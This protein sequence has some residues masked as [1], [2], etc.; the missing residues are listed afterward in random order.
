[1]DFNMALKGLISIPLSFDDFL[2]RLTAPPEMSWL[3]GRGR[4]EKE[5]HCPIAAGAG[6]A[7]KQFPPCVHPVSVKI[8][9]SAVCRLS[10]FPY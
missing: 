7:V 4:L 3:H 1:M 6:A 5:I 9:D 2:G 10:A 8:S